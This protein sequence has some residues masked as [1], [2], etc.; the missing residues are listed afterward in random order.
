VIFTSGSTGLPKGVDVRHRGAMNTIDA[1]NE[2]FEVGGTDRVLALSALEFDASVYD[3]FGMFS[4]GGSLVAVDSEQRAAA[5]TWVEL[6]RHHRVSILNCVP[7]MLDMISS[8]AATGSV[9][10]CGPSRSVGTG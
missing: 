9:I 4:V 3:I 7:S 6:L 10:R 2:W 5:T 1:V 8:W